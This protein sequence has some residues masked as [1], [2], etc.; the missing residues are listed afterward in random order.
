MIGI[1]SDS[2]DNCDAVKKAV[3]FFNTTKCDL[4]I[5][6][7]DFVAPFTAKVMEDL[8]CPVKAVFGNCD[9]ERQ[10]LRKAFKS[11]GSISEEP[12][13]F[14]YKGVKF[15]VTHTHFKVNEYK[16]AGDDNVIIYGHTHKPEI[17]KGLQ[18]LII[19]PGE[20]GGWL[21]GKHSVALLSL[22][23]LRAEIVNL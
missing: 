12:L 4:V 9:G 6:A 5:H 13:K 19:N 20:A 22:K 10:G 16:A 3:S 23:D 7:G 2:H 11:L 18:T 8:N 1:M 14:T 21:T 17:R 15:L